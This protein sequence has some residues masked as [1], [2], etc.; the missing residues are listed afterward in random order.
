MRGVVVFIAIATTVSAGAARGM[1]REEVARVVY[2]AEIGRAFQ[3]FLASASLPLQRCSFAGFQTSCAQPRLSQKDAKAVVQNATRQATKLLGRDTTKKISEENGEAYISTLAANED[4]GQSYEYFS[5]KVAGYLPFAAYDGQV[6]DFASGEPETKAGNLDEVTISG[7]NFNELTH[8]RGEDYFLDRFFE[9]S[10]IEDVIQGSAIE[11]FWKKYV[12]FSRSTDLSSCTDNCKVAVYQTDP[13]AKTRSIAYCEISSIGKTVGAPENC[14]D[15]V[16]YALG[17][18]FLVST[19]M[20]DNPF[21]GRDGEG[22]D[23]IACKSPELGVN[24]AAEQIASRLQKLNDPPNQESYSQKVRQSDSSDASV[25][26][27]NRFETSAFLPPLYE[28]STIRISIEKTGDGVTATISPTVVVSKQKSEDQ[29]DYR[30][31]SSKEAATVR[32]RLMKLMLPMECE[33]SRGM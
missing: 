14:V 27:V 30:L 2:D 13:H 7:E 23:E 5:P 16:V 12:E 1:E 6:R 9:H 18:T 21:G 15:V 32:K 28:I 17:H 22:G 24:A 4:E 33:V 8:K 26:V 29:E 19:L 31:V 25:L 20:L 10:Y 11:E 3:A